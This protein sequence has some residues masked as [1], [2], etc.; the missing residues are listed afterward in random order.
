[1]FV[2]LPVEVVR[3][4]DLLLD[5]AFYFVDFVLR[6]ALCRR[7]VLLTEHL[8]VRHLFEPN[9]I[10]GESKKGNEVLPRM[11][12]LHSFV[13]RLAIFRRVF[14]IVGVLGGRAVVFAVS[15]SRAFPRLFPVV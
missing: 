12:L 11:C 3:L 7:L 15:V 5:L 1:M 4:R 10:H 14:A 9:F 13:A 2:V 6:Q 8:D